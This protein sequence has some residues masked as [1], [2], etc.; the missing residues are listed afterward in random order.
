MISR[1]FNITQYTASQTASRSNILEQFTPPKTV[2]EK[3]ELLHKTM[4]VPLLDNLK[5]DL[6]ISSAY[7]CTT[8]NAL[9]KGAV[10]S[11]HC[12]GESVDLI[13][14]EKGQKV[15]FKLYDKIK[16]LGLPF[17][18]LIKEY[19]DSNNPSWIHISFSDKN[20]RQELIIR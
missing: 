5:G 15:N 20:R 17:D 19:G 6:S 1:D 9:I 16:E 7:R 11:Q 14:Y 10:G 3:L 18:Q 4:V 8:L 13:Y 12:K 2:I